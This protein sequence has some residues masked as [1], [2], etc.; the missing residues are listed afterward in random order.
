MSEYIADV[1][2]SDLIESRHRGNLAVVNSENGLEY[3]TGDP[4]NITYIRSAAK[5][6]QILPVI[7]SGAA[8]FFQFTKQEIAVMSASH[9]G[10]EKH[11]QTVRKI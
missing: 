10:E 6:F 7:N 8:D 11:V 2:R 4:R 3:F 5:P 1:Y 9:N